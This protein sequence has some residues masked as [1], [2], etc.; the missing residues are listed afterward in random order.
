MFVVVIRVLT[1]ANFIPNE[2]TSNLNLEILCILNFNCRD[3]FLHW[4][5]YKILSYNVYIV[6]YWVRHGLQ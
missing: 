4:G 3:T 5:E 6:G 2:G 1:I